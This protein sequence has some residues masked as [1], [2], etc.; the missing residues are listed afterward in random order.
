MSGHV[1]VNGCFFLSGLNFPSLSVLETIA[2]HSIDMNPNIIKVINLFIVCCIEQST[3]HSFL[4][5]YQQQ[6]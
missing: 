2:V 6:S 1:M 3:I 4:Q 5:E